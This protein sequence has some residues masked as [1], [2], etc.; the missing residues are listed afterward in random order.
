MF[1]T[2]YDECPQAQYT[3]IAMEY[4]T[5]PMLEAMQ[6][7]LGEHWLHSHPSA[8]PRLADRI[9]QQ[10]K[11]AFYTDTDEWKQRVL[12]QARQALFQAADGLASSRG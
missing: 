7:M 11:A 3:G 5:V 12:E 8:P 1:S 9:K 2:A 4:G 10:M 6:A